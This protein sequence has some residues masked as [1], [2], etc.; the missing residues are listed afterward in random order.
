M[1][2][3]HPLTILKKQSVDTG[4]L[5]ALLSTLA[6]LYT[7]RSLF[8]IIAAVLLFLLLLYPAIFMLPAVL[9]FGFARLLSRFMSSVLLTLIFYIM[10]LPVGLLRKA[11]GH[12]RLKLKNFN[13]TNSSTW[14]NRNHLFKPDDLT[15]M[16]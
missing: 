14:E 13:R 2:S 16:F 8:F 11:A 4:I 1:P 9:W 15:R 5:L 6:G 10:V 3:H 12:D 7:D